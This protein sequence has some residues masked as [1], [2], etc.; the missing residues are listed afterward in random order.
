MDTRA[1]TRVQLT[2]VQELGERAERLRHVA[3]DA[4]EQIGDLRL[5]DDVVEERDE[6]WLVGAL[7]Y[8]RLA[9]DARSYAR[10]GLLT[11]QTNIN[12]L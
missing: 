11:K 8:L 1:R 3:A 7:C 9:L 12:K 5:A 4:L 10:G 6:N 2:L